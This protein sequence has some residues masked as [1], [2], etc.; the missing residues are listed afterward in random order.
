MQIVIDIPKELYKGIKSRN[1]ELE[2]EY[3]CDELMEAIDNGVQ[4]PKRHG[5]LIDRDVCLAMKS[6]DLVDAD[7]V[8]MYA[9]PTGN[10]L[11]INAVIPAERE[12]IE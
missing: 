7:G 9:V 6:C 10:I 8:T 4:L 3:V 1:P 12:E 2:T 5:D 11:R